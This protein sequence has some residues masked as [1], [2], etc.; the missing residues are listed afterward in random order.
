LRLFE[1]TISSDRIFEGKIINLRVDQVQLPDGKTA[2]REIVEHPGAVVILAITA[3]SELI[4]VRQYRKPVNKE[5]LELPAGKLTPGEDPLACARRELL[6][7]TGYQAGHLELISR[8]YTTPGF[9]DEVMYFYLATDLKE[10]KSCPD[11]DEFIEVERVDL[12]KAR[13]LVRSGQIEDAKTIIGVFS[14]LD[15]YL[16]AKTDSNSSQE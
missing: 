11:E 2:T 13:E 16:K 10:F 5:L 3:N 1:K 7:E 4:L 8:Y 6:E 14:A 15:L 9:S 12:F